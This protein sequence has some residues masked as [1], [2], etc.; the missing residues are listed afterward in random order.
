MQHRYNMYVNRG[1]RRIPSLVTRGEIDLPNSNP[2]AD[3]YRREYS[4]DPLWVYLQNEG[5]LSGYGLY[6][7][8]Y[9]TEQPTFDG[10]RWFVRTAY[11]ATN[12][13]MRPE[14]TREVSWVNTKGMQFW[15]TSFRE[16]ASIHQCKS[17]VDYTLYVSRSFGYCFL[18]GLGFDDEDDDTRSEFT[19]FYPSIHHYHAQVAIN[20]NDIYIPFNDSQNWFPKNYE[21][22]S[23][24]DPSIQSLVDAANRATE[25]MQSW[26][27]A[28]PEL[29]LS[30][31]LG[32]D[33]DI[34]Q[35]EED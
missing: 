23:P 30:A 35:D 24:I 18:L 14:P 4:P 12:G 32:T 7:S 20:E 5:D 2:N 3:D 1:E 10:K 29:D 25:A 21:Q 6:L 34:M 17:I 13:G 11:S 15:N 31:I 26:N 19:N 8:L 9:C 33:E 22:N 16:Y 28:V 27:G